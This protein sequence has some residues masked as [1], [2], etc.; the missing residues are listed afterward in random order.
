FDG[1]RMLSGVGMNIFHVNDYP[2]EPPR[3]QTRDS[4]RVYPGDGIAPLNLVF[5]SLRDVGFQGALSLELF[6]ETY[7]QQPTQT[8]IKTGLQKMKDS[9]ATALA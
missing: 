4:D 1:L 3:E 9:V 7:Y 2:A 8:V 6:N 5:Q